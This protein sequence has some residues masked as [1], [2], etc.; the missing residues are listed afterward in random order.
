MSMMFAGGRPDRRSSADT[1]C[2][3]V[4]AARGL[5]C[6]EHR[7]ERDAIEVRSGRLPVSARTAALPAAPDAPRLMTD[8]EIVALAIKIYESESL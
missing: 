5:C 6:D 2:N 7:A 3:Y 4:R 1:G 8:E